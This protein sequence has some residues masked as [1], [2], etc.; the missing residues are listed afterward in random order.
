MKPHLKR[1][2]AWCV[3]CTGLSI[4]DT[5]CQH[6]GYLL[7]H[8][9]SRLYWPA[10]WWAL[11]LR[12]AVVRVVTAWFVR[13]WTIFNLDD[14]RVREKLGGALSGI[15]TGTTIVVLIALVFV[16]AH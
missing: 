1:I 16:T 15:V 14:P 11:A 7:R 9:D 12:F 8:N 4:E 10:W 13:T 2:R 5:W 6:C 3:H